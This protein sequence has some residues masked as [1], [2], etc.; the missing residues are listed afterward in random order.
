MFSNEQIIEILNKNH[1]I[2]VVGL[3]RDAAKPSYNVAQY[4]QKAGY[5]IFPVNP[6]YTT[7]LNET[8]YPSLSDIPDRV[9]IVD[10]FRRHE[11]IPDVV[12]E[13]IRIKTAVI[14]MQLGLRHEPAAWL[15]TKAG[16]DV[17]MNRC[18][19]IEHQRLL[20]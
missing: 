12:E 11:Y 14:W 10:I 17:V 20:R 1:N 15:A 18:I 16:I 6:K 19:K 5:R 4:L 8:C 9:E 3:S 7:V 13:A 2:A